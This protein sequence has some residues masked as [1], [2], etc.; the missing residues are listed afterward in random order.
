MRPGSCGLRTVNV[1]PL[2]SPQV[3]S[4]SPRPNVL[5]AALILCAEAFSRIVIEEVS[6]VSHRK[7]TRA[8]TPG[9]HPLIGAQTLHG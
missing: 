9:F 8:Y 7:A 5:K 1:R 3:V 2:T 6:A 4:L